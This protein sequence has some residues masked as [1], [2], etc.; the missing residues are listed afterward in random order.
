MNTKTVT[1]LA[2]LFGVTRQAMNKR[3]RQLDEKFIEKN[4][5]N[6]T[7]VNIGG[8]Q[9]LERLYGKVVTAEAE[10]VDSKSHNQVDSDSVKEIATIEDSAVFEL[11]ST[12]IRD[13]NQEIDR[14]TQQLQ[15]K[16]QQIHRQ[17]ELME[18]AMTEN[19][20]V[21]LELKSGK[22]KKRGFWSRREK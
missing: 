1:E 13:K 2:E 17:Q 15:V 11:V 7:V 10:V 12:L 22:T 8:I 14:L 16:D 5:R 9:E 6:I 18:K 20:N 3:V 21:L 4:E 19:T